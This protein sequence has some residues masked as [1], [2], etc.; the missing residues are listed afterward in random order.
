M[1]L[2]GKNIFLWKGV[3]NM[4]VNNSKNELGYVIE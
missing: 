2:V 3:G 4:F 1:K